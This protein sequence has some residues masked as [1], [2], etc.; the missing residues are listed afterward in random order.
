[1]LAAFILSGC[2][3]AS[4]VVGESTAALPQLAAYRLAPGDKLKVTVFNET[5]LTGEYQ[6]SDRGSIAFPLIGEVRAAGLSAEQFRQSLGQSLQN[7]FVR[8]PRVTIEVVNYRPINV[9]G[10]VR[11]SGQ[12]AYRPGISVKDAIAMAGGFTYRANPNVVYLTRASGAEPIT[13]DLRRDEASVLPG[14]NLRV[15]ERYF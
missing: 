14:D 10:E 7:G 9:F 3:S 1:M 6:V 15:P 13:V 11:N 12:Y 5:D 8:N 2:G 4:H